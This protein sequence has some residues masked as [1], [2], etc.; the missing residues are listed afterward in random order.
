MW[1]QKYAANADYLVALIVYLEPHRNGG[2]ARH[3]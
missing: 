2:L 1:R 3:L